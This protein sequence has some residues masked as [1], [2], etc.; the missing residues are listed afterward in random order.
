MQM[1]I[2]DRFSSISPFDIRK[3][4]AYEVFLLINRLRKYR[5]NRPQK[6]RK[7]ANDTWF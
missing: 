3:E 2:C 5:P 1:S 4:K 7:P 6:I